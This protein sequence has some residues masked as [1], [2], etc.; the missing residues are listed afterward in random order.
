MEL[1]FDREAFLAKPEPPLWGGKAQRTYVYVMRCADAFKVGVA[2][3]VEA[4]RRDIQITNPHSV[5]VVMFRSFYCRSYA[6]RVERE[7]HA[8]LKPRHIHGEWFTGPEA[9]IRGAVVAVYKAMQLLQAR[10]ARKR[11]NEEEEQYRRYLESPEYRAE[12]EE[13]LA[14]LE[15]KWRAMENDIPRPV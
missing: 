5:S 12:V 8:I 15:N 9:D 11:R 13:N 7:V 4:R 6:I 2:I 10:Y 3:D 1:T 14:Y